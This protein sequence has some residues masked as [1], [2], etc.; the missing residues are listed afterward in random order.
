VNEGEV[1]WKRLEKFAGTRGV[2]DRSVVALFDAALGLRVRSGTYRAALEDAS[3]EIIT[4]ATA[5]RDL[6]QLVDDGLLEAVGEKRGRHYV[7]TRDVTSIRESITKD[8]K[9]TEK[10]D[11]FEK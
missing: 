6:R 11:P 1:I 3:L 9:K 10:S 7:A 5:G 4:E 2:P 8:R